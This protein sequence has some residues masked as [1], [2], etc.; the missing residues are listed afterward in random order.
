MRKILLLG[1]ISFVAGGVFVAGFIGFGFYNYKKHEREIVGRMDTYWLTIT[2]PN[3]DQYLLESDETFEVPYMA[4]KLSVAPQPTRIYD[5]NE[6]LLGEF[7][8]EKGQ[9]VTSPDDLPIFLRRALVASEDGNFY[10][11]HGI[12]WLATSRAILTDIRHLHLGQ[13]GSTITQQLAK[14]LF[15]TRKRTAGR[16]VYEYFCAKKLE[17]KFTKDQILLMY[18]DFAYFGHGAFGVE[19]ASRYYFQKPAKQLELAEAAMLV[20]IIPNPTKY[21]PYENLGLAQARHRT[22]LTRM[23]KLNFVPTSQIERISKEFWDKMSAKS[24]I[25]EISFWRMKVNEAPYVIEFLRRRL[26]KDKPDDDAPDRFSKER[27]MKGGLKIHTTFDLEVQKAA[28]AAMAEGLREE[29]AADAA[30]QAITGSPIEGSLAAVRPSDGAILALVGGSGFNFNNQ[31]VRAV[32][33]QRPIGS[34]VKPFVFATAFDSGKY[35]PEDKFNDEK[36]HFN[37]PGGRRW[38]PRNYGNKYFGMVTL[39]TAL[40]KSLNS[41]AIQLLQQV[42]VKPVIAHLAEATGKDD[43]FFPRNLSLALGT[44]DMSALDMA[45]AYS[46]FDNGGSP[47][48]PYFL[49]YIEDRDGTVVSDQRQRP[50]AAAPIFKPETISTMTMVMRGVVNSAEGSGYPAAKRTGFN[51]PAAGKTGTTNDYRDA[52][53]VG[54]TPDISAAVWMGHDDMRVALKQGMAGGAVAAPAWMYFIKGVYRNRPTRDFDSPPA[55]K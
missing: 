47:V 52:W 34:S 25:P 51:I 45:R 43:D 19:S 9:Y 50:P 38:D 46:V 20:G 12:N 5:A 27:L 15:T 54:F 49:R 28:E 39:E 4:S 31:L 41:V 48:T 29:N 7:S 11:H 37:L 21:S 16:K 13:G 10:T 53:F 35:T 2:S 1:L 14:M 18:F 33:A 24:R 6:K 30:G 23:G 44:V 55:K 3:H 26:V 40:H 36:I 8:I 32:D 17:E 42:G 22:V